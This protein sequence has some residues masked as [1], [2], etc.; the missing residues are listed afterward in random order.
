MRVNHFR[1][2]ILALLCVWQGCTRST[3]SD[4]PS[5]T[6]RGTSKSMT[7]ATTTSAQDSGLLDVMLPAFE[8][9]SGIQ[10]KVVAVGSGQALELGRRGDA[11]LLLTHSPSDEEKFVEAGWGRNRRPLMHNDFIIAGPA[12]DPAGI[13]QAKSA[14][15]ALRAIAEKS[16]VFVSRGDESGTHKKELTLWKTAGI[17]PEGSWYISSGTG[18]ALSLRMAH[19]KHGYILTDRGT[20]LSLNAELELVVEFEGDPLLRN[21]YSVMEVNP[22]RHPHVKSSEAMLLAEFFL[23]QSGQEIIR[24]FGTETYGQPLFVPDAGMVESK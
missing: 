9:Q 13:K 4:D 19:E 6:G 1:V 20:Y 22:A 12:D 5:A 11:D 8:K 21:L 15:E 3:P 7:L 18:M 17:D 16:C 2:L 23:S 24:T 14:V 10:V